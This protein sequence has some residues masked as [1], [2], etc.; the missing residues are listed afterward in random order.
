MAVGDKGND[1]NVAKTQEPTWAEDTRLVVCG[2][3]TKEKGNT[4]VGVPR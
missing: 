3:E 2:R 4:S 1:D